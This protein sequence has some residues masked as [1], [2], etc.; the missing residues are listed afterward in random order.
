MSSYNNQHCTVF[1]EED[2]NS[3]FGNENILQSVADE[4]DWATLSTLLTPIDSEIQFIQGRIMTI[5]VGSDEADF[6][7]ESEA[8]MFDEKM[9]KCMFGEEGNGSSYICILCT[10]NRGTA[11]SC[12]GQFKITQTINQIIQLAK[13]RIENP[14]NLSDVVLRKACKGGKCLPFMKD[15]GIGFKGLHAELSWIRFFF[16]CCCPC[17]S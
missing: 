15:I 4:N 11:R 13:K 3:V 5:D 2:P 8:A 14:D 1:E 10:A 16:K 9:D 7:S 17:E 6:V 12:L